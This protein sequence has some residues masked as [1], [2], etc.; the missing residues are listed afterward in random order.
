QCKLS[1]LDPTTPC[2]TGQTCDCYGRCVAPGTPDARPRT[3]LPA[4]QLTPPALTIPGT[5]T[6]NTAWQRTID[7]ALT[8][9]DAD[10]LTGTRSP[11]T[12]T[13]TVHLQPGS[14]LQVACALSGTNPVFTDGCDLAGAW[15][16]TSTA[17]TWSASRTVWVK[18]KAGGP[19]AAGPPESWL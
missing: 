8:T 19:G 16:F 14:N 2:P 7:V 6:T 17:G 4:L 9:R 12:F 18:A 13:A 1:C 15:S 11:R 10:L 5:I 3:R